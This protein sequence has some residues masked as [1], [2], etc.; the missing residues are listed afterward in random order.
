M[1]EEKFNFLTTYMH[2]RVFTHTFTITSIYELLVFTNT[3]LSDYYCELKWHVAASAVA[4]V[5]DMQE[6]IN[7]A[8]V[9][10]GAARKKYDYD[11]DYD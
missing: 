5:V 4:C 7:K 8:P 3:T 10:G 2:A 9:Y 11:Y 1:T 6:I